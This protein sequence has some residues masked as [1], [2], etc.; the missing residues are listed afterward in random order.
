L[1]LN[2]LEN[3]KGP[4]GKKVCERDHVEGAKRGRSLHGLTTPKHTNEVLLVRGAIELEYD[5]E[6]ITVLVMVQA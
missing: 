6:M 2:E 3:K 4:T 1:K 5:L